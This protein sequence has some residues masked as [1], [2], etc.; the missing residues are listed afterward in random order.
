MDQAERHGRLG[1][2]LTLAEGRY[3]PG[4]PEAVEHDDGLGG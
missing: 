4:R 3:G 1:L 2:L